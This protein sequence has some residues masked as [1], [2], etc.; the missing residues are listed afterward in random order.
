MLYK[1]P[2]ITKK[3][4]ELLQGWMNFW[5]QKGSLFLEDYT[6]PFSPD[7]SNSRTNL[8]FTINGYKPLAK[9]RKEQ[10]VE[11]YNCF[12]FDI[13]MKDNPDISKILLQVKILSYSYFFDFIVESR[14]GYHLYIL[15]PDGKYSSKEEYLME[16]K[17][18]S[19]ELESIMDIHFDQNI[20]DV[21]RISRI[22][23]SFHQKAGDT[24]YF[25]LKLIKGEDILFPLHEKKNQINRINITEVLDVLDI[26]YQ[27]TIIYENGL[28]TSGYKINPEENYIIDFSH[29]RPQGQP[30]AFVKGYYFHQLKQKGEEKNEGLLMGMTYNFF[31]EHFGITGSIERSKKIIVKEY[32]EKFICEEFAG[33]EQ[34]VLYALIAYYQIKNQTG[35]L[36]G[37]NIEID[38]KDMLQ[39]LSLTMDIKDMKGVLERIIHS[40]K[41]I[42]G[43]DYL[44]L[45]GDIKK[46]GSTYIFQGVLIPDWNTIRNRREFYITHYIPFS[47]FQLNYKNTDLSFYLILCKTFLNQK[48]QTELTIEKSFLSQQ[49]LQDHNFSRVFKR[50]KK[51]E[52][53]TGSF[54]IRKNQKEITFTKPF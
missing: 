42:L 46:Q 44:F 30:F 9:N 14:N 18:K 12:Y 31:K 35:T 36:Y 29:N 48:K 4:E 11:R 27:A 19:E 51:I 43:K 52:S 28:P 3:S 53:I 23:G 10:N 40:K 15:L 6:L 39:Q 7:I 8:F 22:P 17:K 37:K 50:I 1:T 45:T 34:Y 41:T 49:L 13:D 25:S 21:T 38:L 54:H 16:W 26:E 5:K 33:S 24:D 20:F 2:K 32:I 47:L